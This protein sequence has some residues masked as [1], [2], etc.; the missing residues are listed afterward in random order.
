VLGLL[1]FMGYFVG[2]FLHGAIPM[3]DLG[4]LSAEIAIGAASAV[5]IRF[6]AFHPRPSRALTRTQRSFGARA[7]KVM[8][9][10]LAIFDDPSDA[11]RISRRLHHQLV[12]LNEAALMIDAWLG[13]SFSLDDSSFGRLLHQHL[14]DME[15]ALNN[16][17]RFAPVLAVAD[18]PFQ[19]QQRVRSALVAMA[20][21]DARE[22]RGNA[23]RLMDLLRQAGPLQQDREQANIVVT[24]R[25][26]DS[27]IALTN[28]WTSWTVEDRAIKDP[29]SFEPRVVLLAGWLPGSVVVSAGASLASSV[30]PRSRARMA[31]YERAAIQVG[32]A[33]AA[34][35]AVGDQLSARRFYWAVI[36]A[37]VTFMGTYNVG[38]QLNKAFYRVIGTFVG[39]GV[40][41]LLA[42]AVGQ[43]TV[44]AI[45]VILAALFFGFYL[46]RINY[47]FLVLGATVMVS[48]LYV[49]LNQ[50]SDR[51][52]ILRLEETAL[53]SAVAIV[54]VM[55]VVPLHSRRVLR[56]AYQ[57]YLEAMSDL[58]GH[59]TARLLYGQDL[60]TSL[61]GDVRNLD[62]AYQAII[63]TI[64]P[65]RGNILGNFD[66]SA[67]QASRL[68]AA[69]RDYSRN[70]IADA[71][72]AEPI[73]P[74]VRAGIEYA[75][76]TLL[77]SIQGLIR[78]IHGGRD[79]VYVRSAA[80]F[81]KP[82][83]QLESVARALTPAQL[84][85]G[86]FKLLDGALAQ[87]A[88]ILRLRITDFDTTIVNDR[89]GSNE[90]ST[91]AP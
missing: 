42:S 17:A 30:Y 91:R 72:A 67:V 33:V 14:F 63:A 77:D 24:H 52:L 76:G 19:Y 86:E 53:G 57:T 60:T 69:A 28:A 36:A 73:D 31:P 41:S 66:D 21:G 1:L 48:Q 61:P 81:D 37:F 82:Q 25:F 84:A 18:L 85:C 39:I 65:L 70:L 29:G 35:I 38:E 49:Q 7:R 87:L 27:V 8:R 58:I 54:V 10:A 89:T 51:L 62:A 12:R 64:A 80:L 83:R 74:D 2:F 56:F 13:D 26:A 88:G 79:E 50:F 78:A 46:F 40:G 75:S 43:N 90:P 55:L 15:L 23:T 47:A 5:S 32:I 3:Q 34:A 6:A 4:W 16:I 9:V 22:A 20:A 71:D 59:T 68:V 11:D 44:G 45:V